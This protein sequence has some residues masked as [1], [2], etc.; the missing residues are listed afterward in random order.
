MTTVADRLKVISGL[1]G[2]TVSEML[3]AAGTGSTMAQCL[4]SYSGLTSVA[5]SVHL[6]EE[7]AREQQGGGGKPS[8]VK[9][10]KLIHESDL[11]GID[12][13]LR[14]QVEE[15]LQDAPPAK[16]RKARD[17]A[18]RIAKKIIHTPQVEYADVAKAAIW[19]G[20]S[21]NLKVDLT[22][23]FMAHMAMLI[24]EWRDE[25]ESLLLLVA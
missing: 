24:A 14:R 5:V 25:E 19:W 16:R 20:N 18:A 8:R 11:I 3:L 1:S 7:V 2:A 12:P 15:V 22:P 21:L 10:H 4:V 6:L 23:L 13:L 9:R 17:T